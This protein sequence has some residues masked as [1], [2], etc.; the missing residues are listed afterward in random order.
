M[1]C[2]YDFK[3]TGSPSVLIVAIVWVSEGFLILNNHF[4]EQVFNS[5]RDVFT[6][7]I[8]SG[9]VNWIFSVPLLVFRTFPLKSSFVILV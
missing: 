5:K 9:L 8:I 3:Y 7:D 2:V 4:I 1:G 6:I